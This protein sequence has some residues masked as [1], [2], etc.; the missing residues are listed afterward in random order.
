MRLENTL[1]IL[2]QFLTKKGFRLVVIFFEI[3]QV[4][5][6]R[7]GATCYDYAVQKQRKKLNHAQNPQNFL[8]S[9]LRRSRYCT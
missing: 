2:K 3:V 5:R 7:G 6:G 8:H 4:D 1:L 9:R